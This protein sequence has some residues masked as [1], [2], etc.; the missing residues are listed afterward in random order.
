M[1]LVPILNGPSP[2]PRPG[3][4]TS[5]SMNRGISPR[6][7]HRDH[8]VGWLNLRLW[9][10]LLEEGEKSGGSR[11]DSF[12]D[13]P[14]DGA[15]PEAAWVISR[16]IEHQSDRLASLDAM[17]QLYA[18]AGSRPKSSQRSR[19]VFASSLKTRIPL[20]LCALPAR[21]GVASQ[22]ACRSRTYLATTSRGTIW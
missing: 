14:A 10:R 1:G 7:T 8:P 21:P 19:Y 15:T 9:G 6:E 16:S 3:P 20:S 12:W 5:V 18:D 22:V 17:P 11:C 2:S 13:R 4:K